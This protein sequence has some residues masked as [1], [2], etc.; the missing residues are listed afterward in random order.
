MENEFSHIAVEAPNGMF[1]SSHYAWHCLKVRV[2]I[3]E[4]VGHLRIF[5]GYIRLCVKLTKTIT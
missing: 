4:D 3:G 2:V 5:R 1:E